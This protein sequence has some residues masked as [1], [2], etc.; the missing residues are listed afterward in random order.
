MRALGLESW[1]SLVAYSKQTWAPFAEGGTIITADSLNHIEQGIADA[2][3]GV[4]SL[5]SKHTSDV[6]TINS[7]IS[8]ANSKI[9]TAQT[10]ITSLQSTTKSLD[11]RVS[12]LEANPA[13]AA[14]VCDLSMTGFI[15][16]T[17][18][19]GNQYGYIYNT[20]SWHVVRFAAASNATAN[21]I[22]TWDGN[23]T[24]YGSVYG[25]GFQV[26]ADC[27]AAVLYAAFASNDGKAATEGRRCLQLFTC[28]SA[29]NATGVSGSVIAYNH[30]DMYGDRPAF[31]VVVA[32]GTRVSIAVKWPVQH[33]TPTSGV[34]G[35][36]FKVVLL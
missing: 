1:C 29:G 36:N 6:N 24:L 9:S 5:Q 21:G 28:D 7:S 14:R 33:A 3:S 30:E 23:G 19:A 20:A 10:N 25:A 13:S 15:Y 12:A 27:E 22:T 34:W 17:S 8:S 31:T 18:Q 4:S 35:G 2:H 11:T 32:P 16:G 26:P